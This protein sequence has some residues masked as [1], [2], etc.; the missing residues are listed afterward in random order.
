MARLSAWLVRVMVG[1]LI[2]TILWALAYRWIN[3]PATALMIRD[4]WSG[5]EVERTWTDLEDMSPRIA[6]AALAAEDARFCQHN[7]FDFDAISEAMR[8][9]ID[10]K[11]LRGGSTISQQV[12]K[13]AFLWPERSWLRKGLE[14]YFTV[15]IET[16]WPKRRILE[17][18]LN[19]AEWGDG[20]YGAEAASRHYFGRS[21]ERLTRTQAA[22]L[23]SI[24]PA[25]KKWSP[26]APSGKVKRKS[27]GVRRALTY[28]EREMGK[29]LELE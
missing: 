11:K 14:A 13:N 22:R 24:L 21:S 12:A 2:F 6:Y 9:N 29:C 3:P 19:V 27:R 23:V 8:A 17:V 16:F 4:W 7:G 1:L 20:I 15:L 25:P 26:T 5:K 28:V 18:Y 10:G